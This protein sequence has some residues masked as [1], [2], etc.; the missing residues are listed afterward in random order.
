LWSYSAGDARWRQ[1]SCLSFLWL[2]DGPP[3]PQSSGFPTSR[4]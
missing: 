4:P 2:V 3:Q 1:P